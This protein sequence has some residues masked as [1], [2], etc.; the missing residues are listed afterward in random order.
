MKKSH[1]KILILLLIY[2]VIIVGLFLP[3][4]YGLSFGK[5]AF[6]HQSI[7][8]TEFKNRFETTY[9]GIQTYFGMYNLVLVVI[10]TL[11]HKTYSDLRI[12]IIL[13]IIYL[14]SL[15]S[16]HIL[17]SF[18]GIGSPFSDSFLTGRAVIVLGT[19][20]L[21]GFY[22]RETLKKEHQLKQNIDN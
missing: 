6:A 12:V 9:L 13:F 4:S 17:N 21:F 14:L 22:F 10:L 8:S 3:Y 7:P 11:S 15:F 20:A 16:T 1:I 2:V 18:T 19:I 5:V